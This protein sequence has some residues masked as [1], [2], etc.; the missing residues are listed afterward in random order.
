[1]VVHS[2]GMALPPYKRGTGCKKL[3]LRLLLQAADFECNRVL[4]FV[5]ISRMSQRQWM[6]SRYQFFPETTGFTCKLT[7]TAAVRALF[8]KNKVG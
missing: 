2:P 6:S 5:N 7:G 4:L 3:F 1:M 8:S